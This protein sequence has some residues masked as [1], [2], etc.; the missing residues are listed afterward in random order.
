[1]SHV[2]LPK[3]A[4][5]LIRPSATFSPQAGRRTRGWVSGASLPPT[6]PS[7]RPRPFP[8]PPPSPLPPRLGVS[9][10][11]ATARRVTLDDGQGRGQRLIE[12]ETGGGLAFD[13]LADRTLDLGQARFRGVPVA[14]IGPNGYR[15]PFLP[16]VPEHGHSPMERGLAG[17]M[18]TCGFEHARLPAPRERPPGFL[19]ANH[20]LH[21][22]IP[23]TPA[24]EVNAR[25]DVESGV[26]RVEGRV[27][28]FI[29]DGPSYE[30]RRTI[31]APLGGAVIEI[32]DAV[33]NIG[34]APAPLMALYHFNFGWPAVADGARFERRGGNRGGG[35]PPPAPPRGGAGPPVPFAPLPLTPLGGEPARHVD[36]APS[37]AREGRA[38][39]RLAG[40]HVGV[41]ID[42]DAAALPFL[43]S[44][45]RTEPGLNVF[46]VEPITHRLAPRAELEAAGELRALAPG[47]TWRATFRIAFSAPG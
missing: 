27:T 37:L 11:L 23:F 10:Q 28:Q 30:L 46:S 32:A 3:I 33:A 18:T 9:A 38:A 5:P 17:L 2:L 1:M 7:P 42:Y 16:G 29:L 39:A 41:E 43:Q 24:D 6:Q 8:P 13:V 20:P 21:G 25:L 47:E 12:V 35:G 44:W 14:W 22:S 45:R 36:C 34:F 19:D 4:P 40:P 31:V 26:L 15:S